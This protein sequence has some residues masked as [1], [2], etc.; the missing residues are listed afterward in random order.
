MKRLGFVDDDLE[1]YH[2]NV[3]LKALR[4]PL[5]S[6]GVEL[7]GCTG[8]KVE[9]GRAWA[10]KNGVAW[11][12]T[13]AELDRHVDFYMILAPSTPETHLGLCEQVVPRKRPVYVDKT[14]A[15]DFAT[16]VK[17]FELAD[18]HGTPLQTSSAL[19]YTNIHEKVKAMR[20]LQVEHAIAWGAGG[21]YD[22]YAIHPLELLISLMGP[23][24]VA[25]M[26]RGPVE[27][28]QLLLEFTRQRTG[29][30]NVYPKSNTP[31]AANLTT[32]AGSQYL[33]VDVGAIFENNLGAILDFLLSSK[34]NV[35]RRE[36][37]AILKI[38]DVARRPEVRSGFVQL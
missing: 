7:T 36:T 35:D 3:F 33:E 24:V 12:D 13:V 38:L 27:R 23:E 30:V 29:V 10:S 4:G 28:T 8:L 1:N 37:L 9:S 5:K 18:R 34:P 15:P 26:R 20:P 16:A 6:R 11:F 17:I 14:F 25:V 21:S 32:S 22:E 19:R 31:F 2:A